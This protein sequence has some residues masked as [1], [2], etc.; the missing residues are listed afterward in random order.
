MPESFYETTLTAAVTATQDTI[1]VTTAPNITAGYMVIEANTSNREIIKYT[2]V[3]G[4]TLTGVVRGLA[5]YGSDSSAGTG[6]AHPA[7][8]DIANKDVHYYYSQYYDFLMGTSATGAN[9]MRIGDGNT[10]SAG[11]WLDTTSGRFWFVNTSSLSAYW[12]LSSNGQFVCSENGVDSYVVSAGGSGVTGGDGLVITAGV[13]DVDKLST[14]GLRISATK[15]AVNYDGT[16]LKGTSAG[17]LYFD[18]TADYIW[19]GTNTFG[20]AVSGLLN[21]Y[22]NGADGSDTVAVNTALSCDTYY[23]SLTIN[24]GISLSSKGFRIFC[25]DTLSCIGTG[26][27]IASGGDGG[28]GG[29]ASGGTPGTGGTAGTAAYIVGSLPVPPIANAG[30]AGGFAGA[31]GAG[32]DGIS[33][34]KALNNNNGAAGGH[35]GEG[36]SNG[37]VSGAG[38]ASSG[39]IYNTINNYFNSERLFDYNGQ[40]ISP[41]TINA[42]P[43]SGGGGGGNVGGEAG[44]GGG[45]AGAPGGMIWVAARN[46]SNINCAANGGKGGNGGSASSVNCGRG[47]G[48]AGGN[49]G[50]VILNYYSGTIGTI[51]VSAGTGGAIGS[52]G[53]STSATS[54]N[55][56][57]AGNYYTVNI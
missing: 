55:P 4:T 45:G 34:F 46:I 42:G 27:I 25:R 48:G 15:L 53:K 52:T 57:Y 39:T 33:A 32:T 9:S 22:G 29:N 37:G 51:G 54:G 6:K 47:G 12:G 13:M 56:G 8:V 26:C 10:V 38:G 19:T 21:F 30:G 14:G 36:G 3:S 40:S 20:G 49:G 31:G 35:G 1:P 41:F 17:E 7:G 43:G 11:D 18:K 44:G 24:D 23:T 50:V 28:N 5:T 2:G 16:A